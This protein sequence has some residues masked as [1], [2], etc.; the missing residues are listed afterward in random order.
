MRRVLVTFLIGSVWAMGSVTYRVSE[1]AA[2]CSDVRIPAW[3]R[4][5]GSG[6][7][8]WQINTWGCEYDVRTRGQLLYLGLS[9]GS[10]L[11]WR[12]IE[13]YAVDLRHPEGIREIG[14]AMW[15]TASVQEPTMGG[16]WADSP[17]QQGDAGAKFPK[18]GPKYAGAAPSPGGSRIAVDSW[19]GTVRDPPQIFGEYPGSSLRFIKDMML[20]RYDGQYWI[21]IYDQ[22]SIRRLVQIRGDFHGDSP[23]YFQGKAKWLN[24]RYYLLPLDPRGMRR[25]LVCDIDAAARVRGV[26]ES[27][28]PVPLARAKPF[29]QHSRSLYQMRFLKPETPQAHITGFHDEPVINPTTGHIES[30][31]VTASLDVQ[32]PGEYSL[33]LDLSDV[34]E[35][36]VSAVPF[37]NAEL[38]VAFPVT[39]LRELGLGGPYRIRH[40]RL[41]RIVDDGQIVAENSFDHEVATAAQLGTVSLIDASTQAYSL[42]SLGSSL[43][44]TGENAATL[45]PSAG[46]EPERLQV[47]IGI[48]SQET[49]CRGYG[50][51]ARAQL[52]PDNVVAG[53]PGQRTLVLN[54]TG[55]GIS[56]PGPY[57][58]EQVGIRCGGNFI[59]SHG[60]E[61]PTK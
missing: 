31:N 21:D 19:S 56:E 34:Q 45:I 58:I 46:S 41:I 13:K 8:A 39:R 2:A 40:A 18:S 50:A 7:P 27:D 55:K 28:A 11:Y 9:C 17:R 10:A 47:R 53:S 14:E 48:Y 32:I 38:T 44:F 57:H 3:T 20:A 37:G 30:V 61:I 6:D 49:R 60:I 26:A 23:V 43:Y 35:R 25:L 24:G 4:P 5:A 1:N 52:R 16:V 15:D 29:L 51:L 22:A 33:E 59:Q 54:F 12:M 42:N 36:A